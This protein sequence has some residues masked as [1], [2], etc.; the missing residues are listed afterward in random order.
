M[1]IYS[2][3]SRYDNLLENK[4]ALEKLVE[5]KTINHTCSSC[6]KSFGMEIYASIVIVKLELMILCSIFNILHSSFYSVF[7]KREMN[8]M[9]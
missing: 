5:P 3:I 6:K 4:K 1:P 7:L 8:M 2:N 9:F